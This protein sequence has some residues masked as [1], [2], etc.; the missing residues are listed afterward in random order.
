M[1]TPCFR[2]W[3]PLMNGKPDHL[4]EDVMV[5]AAARIHHL[6]VA[7]KSEHDF[8]SLGIEWVNPFKAG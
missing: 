4:I 5:A 1:D 7:S 6:I 8:E 3:G 2:A